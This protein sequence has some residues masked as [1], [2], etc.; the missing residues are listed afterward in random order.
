LFLGKWFLEHVFLLFVYGTCGGGDSIIIC[1]ISTLYIKLV[2]LVE[3]NIVFVYFL[4][5][6]LLL[7]TRIARLLE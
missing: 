6:L 7:C 3:M 5:L 1:F 4:V 2:L